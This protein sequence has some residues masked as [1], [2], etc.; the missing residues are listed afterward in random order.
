MKSV[1]T[2]LINLTRFGDLVQSQAA[3]RDLALR[4]R[5]VAVVCLENFSAAAGLLAHVDHLFPLPG[6]GLMAALESARR[7]PGQGWARALAD[8]WAWKENLLAVFSPDEVCNLTPSLPARLLARFLAGPAPCS[9]FAVDEYGFSLFGGEWAAFLQGAGAARGISPFNV[10]DLFRRVAQ[11]SAG[12]G[13]ASLKRPDAALLER[14]GEDLRRAAPAEHKGFVALQLGASEE[15]RRW[16]AASFAALGGRLWEEERL[17]P[18][19]LGSAGEIPLA[20]EYLSQAGH[21]VLSLCGRTS[22]EELAAALCSARLLVTNDTGTMHLAAG[23]NRPLLAIFLATAQPF[24][25]GPYCAGS[26]CLE[27]DCPCHPCS[28]GQDCSRD[29]VCRR[30][31][32]PGLAADLALAFL[33]RGSWPQGPFSGPGRVWLSVLGAD[34]FMD[35]RSLSGHEGGDRVLWLRLLRRSMSQFLDGGAVDLPERAALSAPLG[36]ALRQ[37]L[38]RVHALALLFLRQ[39]EMLLSSAAPAFLKDRFLTTWQRTSRALGQNPLLGAM[40]IL[41][42]EATQSEGQELP[43]I[44]AVVKRFVQLLAE[45]KKSIS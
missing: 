18:V 20:E 2:L 28:F 24:D 14:V 36:E 41:W 39:G 21:P 15:R 16:P 25:T 3:I 32:E 40:D 12:P 23:L 35:L 37:D 6:A 4:G 5:R 13:D 44:L 27:P 11:S 31:L 45:L 26:C 19:L 33:R 43:Q 8:L 7:E 1:N 22:L 38:E 34:G 9:G 17:C 29:L 30:A 10:A 42:L